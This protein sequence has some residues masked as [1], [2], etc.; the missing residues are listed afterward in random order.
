MGK[1]S[2]A[3]LQDAPRVDPPAGFAG[4]CETHALLAAAKDPLHTHVLQL[5]R[6]ATVRIGPKD[7]DCVVYVW[8]GAVE[9][10][11]RALAATSSLIV[12]RGAAIALQGRDEASLLVTFSAAQPSAAARPGGHVHLLPAERVPRAELT[13]TRGA[14]GGLH[15]DAGCPSCE[16]WLHENSLAPVDDEPPGAGGEKGVHSHSEDEVIFVTAGQMRLGARLY[17]PGAAVAIPAETLYSFGVGPDGLSFVNFRAG[18]PSEIK[19]KGGG[20]MDEVGF[21]RDRVGAP[22]YL[23]PLA[24]E[25]RP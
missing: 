6:D 22:D 10:G 12:E 25:P 14:A 5:E 9:A 1:I 20:V 11:G 18:R 17:G 2:I 21:W 3:T 16:V 4:E 19:F 15:A 24:A 23:A 8:R 13:G 7:T